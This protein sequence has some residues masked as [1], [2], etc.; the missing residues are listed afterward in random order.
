MLEADHYKRYID[1]QL[2]VLVAHN[3]SS[4][5]PDYLFIRHHAEAIMQIC[6]QAKAHLPIS[7]HA[8]VI[9]RKHGGGSSS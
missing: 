6:D 1:E 4:K 8:V 5:E 7:N 3:A 2:E 9:H